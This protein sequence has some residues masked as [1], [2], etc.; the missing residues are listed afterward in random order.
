MIAIPEIITHVNKIRLPF[1]INAFS[2]A[3]AVAALN[4]SHEIEKTVEVI[5]KERDL[6]F[7]S[8]SHIPD[9]IPYPSSANFIFFKVKN[10]EKIYQALLKK[11]ILIRNMTALKED[12]FRVTVG[13]PSD[14]K[15][16]LNTLKEIV[17]DK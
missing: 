8:L 10:G 7:D 9:V 1:N 5:R 17:T 2:Q 15:I 4:K 14:N 6:M 16:F 3:L 11:G 12:F 13:T